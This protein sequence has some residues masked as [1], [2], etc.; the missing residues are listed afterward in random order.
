MT[1]LDRLEFL[2]SFLRWFASNQQPP[3]PAQ[4]PT[5]RV[6]AEFSDSPIIVKGE[7]PMSF[8]IATNQSIVLRLT[9]SD[10]AQHAAPVEN[11]VWSL[12]D[13]ALATLEAAADGMSAKISAKGAAGTVAGEVR[14]D[15]RIGDGENILVGAFEIEIVPLEASQITITADAPVDVEATGGGTDPAPVDPNAPPDPANTP[16]PD[17][18]APPADPTAPAV[19]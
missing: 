6:R 16:I 14:A 19:L 15:S 9:A 10:R 18:N 11:T 3:V 1:D 13:S 5:L 2:I 4:P 17:P 8:R 7:L 12:A